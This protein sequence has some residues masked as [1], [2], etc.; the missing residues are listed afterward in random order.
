MTEKKSAA[1]RSHSGNEEGIEILE[2]DSDTFRAGKGSRIDPDSRSA[3]NNTDILIRA[4]EVRDAEK[5]LE[6][7]APYVENTAIS[8]ELKVPDLSEFSG[9]IQ[10]TLSKYPYILAEER[11]SGVILGY[12]CTGTFKGRE[13][14]D[15]AVETSIY[16][17][18]RGQRQGLGRKLYETLEEISRA[19]NIYN[20]CAC[21]GCPIVPDQYL[22]KN[23]IEF[24]AHLGYRMVGQFHKCGYKFGKWYDMVWM[25]KC[26]CS[27]PEVPEPVIPFP[28]L[29]QKDPMIRSMLSLSQEQ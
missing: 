6:I 19:Q 16:V 5:L 9:R 20:L 21:I 14:Y 13:A 26:L 24:H 7:Y 15:H 25:E 12:A 4:A 1:D 27:H 8:F 22:T 10:K 23:S 3:L 17:H 11:Q 2:M 18:Q 29:L 28:E